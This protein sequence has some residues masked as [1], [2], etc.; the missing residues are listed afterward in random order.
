MPPAQTP[1]ATLTSVAE[2]A[3]VLKQVHQAFTAYQVARNQFVNSL[4][5]FMDRLDANNVTLVALMTSDVMAVLCCPL[6]QDPVPGI[7]AL[8]LSSLSKLSACDPLLSQTVASC[9]ILQ[10]VI[11][12][13]SHENA[14]VQAAANMVLASVAHSS[15]DFAQKVLEAGILPGLV[16]QLQTGTVAVKE[17]AVRTLNSLVC[18]SREKAGL[19]CDDFILSILVA[20]L[21]SSDSPPSLVKAAVRTLGDTASYSHELSAAVV[22]ARALPL[23]G[24]LVR[25]P[26]GGAGMVTPEVRAAAFNTLS[27]VARHDEELAAEVVR[28]GVVAAAVLA[29]TDKMTPQVR[30]NAASLLLVVTQKTPELAEAVALSGAPGCLTRYLSMEKEG[31]GC[32]AGIMM[33]GSMASYHAGVAQSLIDAGTSGE[34]IAGLRSPDDKISGA[35]GWA[36]EQMAGHG[37]ETA[38]CLIKAGALG[39]LVDVYVRAAAPCATEQ[40]QLQ[41]QHEAP[42]VTAE[43]RGKLKSLKSSIKTM[44]RGCSATAALE[45]MVDKA[46]PAEVV[47]HVLSRLQGLLVGDA[48]ARQAFVTSGALMRLQQVDACQEEEASIHTLVLALNS[49]FPDDIVE[50]YR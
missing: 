29:L 32:L 35:A 27:Q 4:S 12:S 9:G 22:R 6:A 3:G 5:G 37:E 30:R 42:S 10:G 41:R 43:R 48:K 7:Q 46:T 23:V 39:A 31:R 14:P 33:A 50:Y 18:S 40:Q 26:T 36:L 19:I 49:L 45:V 2:V 21:Q 11:L 16:T 38:A 28:S 17:A 13:M 44:V 24:A 34:V 20:L 25:A 8:A 1:K 15:P 47:G